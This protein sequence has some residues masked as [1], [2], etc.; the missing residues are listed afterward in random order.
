VVR[1]ERFTI[2]RNHALFETHSGRVKPLGEHLY[3][4]GPLFR[5]ANSSKVPPVCPNGC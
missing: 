4:S 5:H 3:P 2:N 1:L